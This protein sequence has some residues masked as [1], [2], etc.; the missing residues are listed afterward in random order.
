M[1][2]LQHLEAVSRSEHNPRLNTLLKNVLYSD[3]RTGAKSVS[4]MLRDL[5]SHERINISSLSNG[6][7]YIKQL[8][9]VRQVM[10]P[11]HA[12]FVDLMRFCLEVMADMLAENNS[13]NYYAKDQRELVRIYEDVQAAA[14]ADQE[15]VE[16]IFQKSGLAKSLTP[17]PQRRIAALQLTDLLIQYVNSFSFGHDHIQHL[18]RPDSTLD[19]M[20]RTMEGAE[21]RR[22]MNGIEEYERVNKNY[23]LFVDDLTGARNQEANIAIDRVSL[24]VVNADLTLN[25]NVEGKGPRKDSRGVDDPYVFVPDFAQREEPVMTAF[26]E[27]CLA[28][29]LFGMTELWFRTYAT[30]RWDQIEYETFDEDMATL[31]DTK[32]THS[33]LIT[34]DTFFNLQQDLNVVYREPEEKKKKAWVNVDRFHEGGQAWA[35]TYQENFPEAGA[36]TYEHNYPAYEG[37]VATGPTKGWEERHPYDRQNAPDYDPDF[38]WPTGKITRAERYPE[39][40]DNKTLMYALVVAGGGALLYYNS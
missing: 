20:L 11:S 13:R 33:L 29:N 34:R 14:E 8:D 35:G 27:V 19:L 1:V 18:M 37:D 32:Y 3:F 21:T 10:N 12:E 16:R 39:E 6:R 28:Y 30:H 7:D 31:F 24:S 2:D 22:R 23:T 25:P 40:N 38:R 17:D 26:V 9:L 5:Y 36:G 15:H 4:G